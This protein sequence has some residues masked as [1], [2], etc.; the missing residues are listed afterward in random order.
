MR[1]CSILEMKLNHC[2]FTDKRKIY[3]GFR[4]LIML[5][6]CANETCLV[7]AFTSKTSCCCELE[8]EFNPRG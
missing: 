3:D 6:F 2:Y 5:S 4:I 7:V 8:K 1:S